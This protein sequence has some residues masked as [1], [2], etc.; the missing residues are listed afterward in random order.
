V[1]PFLGPVSTDIGD[2]DGFGSNEI[3]MLPFIT[4][5]LDLAFAHATGHVGWNFLTGGDSDPD[6]LVYG[7]GLLMPVPKLEDYLAF[8][9]EFVGEQVDV[10]GKPKTVTW[11]PGFDVRIPAGPVSVL[12]RPTGQ[13]GITE[14]GPDWGVG[15]SIAIAQAPRA[16]APPPPPAVVEEAPPPPP[17]PPAPVAEKKIVLRG[18][19]FDFDKSDIRADAAPVLDAAVEALYEAGDVS[20]VCEGHTDAMGTDEYNQRLSERRAQ[21]V[22]AYLVNGG[23]PARRIE[24]VGF[25]ESSPVADNESED[26][27][28][29]NRRVE[30]RVK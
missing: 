17:P 28:A 27:R 5:G 20:V 22:K 29:Q 3:E 21:A 16:E 30:L 14:R 9:N 1:L 26:G 4:G 6:S 2:Q 15:G 10:K 19:N 13:M 23:I 24:A 12:L 11:L 18:V 25:G 7:F 8:R